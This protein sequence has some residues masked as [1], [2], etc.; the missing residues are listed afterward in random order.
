[1]IGRLIGCSTCDI[2][3]WTTCAVHKFSWHWVPDSCSNGTAMTVPSDVPTGFYLLEF[4]ATWGQN[5]PCH[6]QPVVLIKLGKESRNHLPSYVP[7]SLQATVLS[8]STFKGSVPRPTPDQWG[9]SFP[10]CPGLFTFSP[11]GSHS[12]SSCLFPSLRPI[13]TGSE[14]LCYIPAEQNPDLLLKQPPTAWNGPNTVYGHKTGCTVSTYQPHS[15]CSKKIHAVC[16]MHHVGMQL[17]FFIIMVF[18]YNVIVWD[19]KNHAHFLQTFSN[20]CLL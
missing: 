3:I 1:M 13:T 5:L 19:K 2:C 10:P 16:F 7:F 18:Q 9:I 14:S 11:L 20:H 8:V 15:Q 12:I 6:R 17:M 4:R